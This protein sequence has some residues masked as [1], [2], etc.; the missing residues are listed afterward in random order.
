[1]AFFFTSDTHFGHKNIIEYCKRPFKD[2]D[3]MNEKLI[4]NWNSVV[5]PTDVVYHL[6]DFA[7]RGFFRYKNRLNGTI[8]LIKGNHDN[9]D[10][11]NMESGIVHI[12]GKI[13]YLCHV[14]P[15]ENRQQYCLC[16]H[17][18][19]KWKSKKIGNKYLINVGVDVWGYKPISIQ[20]ILSE[21]NRLK[22]LKE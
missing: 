18:H 3:E 2:V 8:H 15:L 14:P 12:G 9:H 4:E 7:F 19:E 16:G 10:E 1:M 13:F 6:G 11:A 20:A 21:I 17:I 22:V 5:Q